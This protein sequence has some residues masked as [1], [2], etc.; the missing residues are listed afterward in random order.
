MRQ[1][2]K[3]AVDV[4]PIKKPCDTSSPNKLKP[5]FDLSNFTLVEEV[6][7]DQSSIAE[8]TNDDICN[9]SATHMQ[10]QPGLAKTESKTMITQLPRKK[11]KKTKLHIA[12]IQNEKALDEIAEEGDNDDTIVDYIH[13]VEEEYIYYSPNKEAAKKS[14][15][16]TENDNIATNYTNHGTKRVSEHDEKPDG[17]TI[18]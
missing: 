7:Y 8:F 9:F 2:R 6:S 5:I 17:C 4:S 15:T 18:F 11:T 3:S 14:S 10:E 1:R 16:V 12:D 13:N